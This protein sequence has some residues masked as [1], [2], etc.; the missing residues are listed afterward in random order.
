MKAHDMYF[1]FKL[2]ALGHVNKTSFIPAS[3]CVAI[4]ALSFQAKNSNTV[5]EL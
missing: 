2:F 5:S 1:V 4:S 3:L